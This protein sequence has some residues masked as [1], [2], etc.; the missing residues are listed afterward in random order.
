MK[1]TGH[2]R[3]MQAELADPAQYQIP[4][5]DERVPANELIGRKLTLTYQGEIHCI[6]CGRKTKKSFQQGYCYPCFQSLPECDSCVIKPELCHYHEGTCRDAA[7]GEK[8][9]LNDH[10]VYLAN[11]SGIKVGITRAANIPSRWLD[12]GAAQALAIYKVKDRLTSGRVEVAFKDH[13]ADKT[14]WQRMLK[15]EPEPRDLVAVRDELFAKTSSA[16]TAIRKELGD[17]AV[18]A[19]KDEKP[20]TIKYPVSVYP[21]KVKSI[22]LEKTPEI[23]GKLLGIKGQYLIFDC[24]V[25]NIRKYAGYLLTLTV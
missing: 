12:Q 25:I 18:T 4:V 7:W 6:A 5:D 24:G 20:V 8:H 22:N 3:K 23:S 16:M 14:A 19:L 9:C 2:I 17:D 11:S 13:V 1:I 15:G 21:E 10:Y